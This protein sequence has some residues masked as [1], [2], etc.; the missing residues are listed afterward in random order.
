MLVGCP[1]SLD[2]R[3]ST[4]SINKISFLK[5]CSGE[6]TSKVLEWP[7]KFSLFAT[8]ELLW[9]VVNPEESCQ[10]QINGKE[11]IETQLLNMS[12]E[13]FKKTKRLTNRSPHIIFRPRSSSVFSNCLPNEEEIENF[14]K[15]H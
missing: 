13:I 11:K 5:K 7:A 9:T 4:R 1:I 2:S 3:S 15:V 12:F 6:K 8:V 10:K 14:P